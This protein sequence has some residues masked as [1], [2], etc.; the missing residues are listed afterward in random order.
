MDDLHALA[1]N[2]SEGNVVFTYL[3]CQ[4]N[5]WVLGQDP[6][7]HLLVLPGV[8]RAGRIH[9]CALGLGGAE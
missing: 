2:K 1:K 4:L 8:D 3:L 5:V 9:K 7:H 6:R